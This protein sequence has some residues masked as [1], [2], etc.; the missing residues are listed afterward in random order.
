LTTLFIASEEIED[1]NQLFQEELL[2][3]L[4]NQDNSIIRK[5]NPT[6]EPPEFYLLNDGSGVKQTL[7]CLCNVKQHHE[8]YFVF[9]VVKK[10][11]HFT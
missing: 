10:E 8:T 4:K 2:V 6:T 11:G 7:A 5:K 9:A 3:L 1:L